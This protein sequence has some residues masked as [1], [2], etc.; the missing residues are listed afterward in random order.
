M[1]K[2][3]FDVALFIVVN[4]DEKR[5]AAFA[6]GINRSANLDNVKKIFANMK[7][8]GYRKA[9]LVQIIKAEEVPEDIILV[10]RNGNEIDRKDAHKYFL[11]LDGQHRTL[12]ASMYNDWLLENGNETIEVPA[13]YAELQAGETISEYINDLS[14]T[15]LQWD[16]TDY[17]QGAANVNPENQ[18]LQRYNELIKS[19]KNPDGYPLSTLNRIYCDNPKALRK[20]DLSL[21]CAGKTEKGARKKLPII[22]AHNLNIG[23]RFIDLCKERGF[24]DSAIARRYL[25]EQLSN[26]RTTTG[27]VEDAFKVFDAITDNDKTVMYTE[28]QKISEERVISQFELIKQRVL[29]T[30]YPQR[31]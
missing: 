24:D 30:Y 23:N 15:K 2:I 25:S 11:V 26:I 9:E 16:I 8:K 21:L 22:P 31:N 12:A 10:D 1:K 20:E 29:P 7:I 27:N 19:K 3:Y 5:E 4:G 17:V 14:I 28:K 13:I 6:R 18:L